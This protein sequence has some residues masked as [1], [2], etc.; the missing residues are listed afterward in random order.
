MNKSLLTAMLSLA[1]AFGAQAQSSLAY[2]SLHL[3]GT[4]SNFCS[5]APS[6]ATN[7]NLVIDITLQ[8]DLFFFM[9]GAPDASASGIL[10][11]V[12]SPSMSATDLTLMDSNTVLTVSRAMSTAG[13][14]TLVSTNW[15]GSPMFSGTTNSFYQGIGGYQYLV[16]RYITNADATANATNVNVYY[17]TKRTPHTGT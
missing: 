4:N 6:T 2:A 16:L 7:L 15:S 13:L 8:R 17:S 10:Q 14:R 3:G 5:I 12:L 11:A 9:V 1:C